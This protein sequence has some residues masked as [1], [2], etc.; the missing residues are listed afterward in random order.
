MLLYFC[1]S[2]LGSGLLD[3]YG[4]MEPSLVP[5][6]QPAAKELPLQL[7]V[8]WAGLVMGLHGTISEYMYCVETSSAR[9]ST[10]DHFLLSLFITG[11]RWIMLCNTVMQNIIIID[12]IILTGF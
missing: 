9:W 7:V 10:I 4:H 2:E 5:S 3:Y 11:E 12:N 8:G 1:A 6:P